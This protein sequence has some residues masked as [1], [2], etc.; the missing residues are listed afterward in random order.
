MSGTALKQSVIDRVRAS[1]RLA[2]QKSGRPMI[3]IGT[4]GSTDYL[5]D[6]NGHKR[7]WNVSSPA[8]APVVGGRSPR[9]KIR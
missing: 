6:Q 7:Y 1:I 4:S 8:N 3:I 5:N 9:S 2:E